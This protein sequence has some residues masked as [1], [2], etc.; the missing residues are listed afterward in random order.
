MRCVNLTL[1]SQPFDQSS[2]GYVSEKNWE[3]RCPDCFAGVRKLEVQGFIQSPGLCFITCW[4]SRKISALGEIFED[5]VDPLCVVGHVDEEARLVGPRAASSVDAH[6]HDDLD[7]PV[8]THE[9]AAVIPLQRNTPH[10]ISGREVA[11][12]FTILTGLN[13]RKLASLWDAAVSV[14]MDSSSPKLWQHTSSSDRWWNV[15]QH[16]PAALFTSDDKN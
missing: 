9:R 8:P 5:L 13:E 15:V 2:V 6:A 16:S 7:P 14:N 1:Y 12:L 10:D 4:V 3:T 11:S